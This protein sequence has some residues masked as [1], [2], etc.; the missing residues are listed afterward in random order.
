MA[1]FWHLDSWP[2]LVRE[3]LCHNTRFR[4]EKSLSVIL[5]HLH[6]CKP[7]QAKGQFTPQKAFPG[8]SLTPCQGFATCV[9][10]H[11]LNEL[12]EGDDDDESGLPLPDRA[13]RSL[14]LTP[15]SQV[16]NPQFMRKQTMHAPNYRAGPGSCR[17]T[18][19]NK[20]CKIGNGGGKSK[21]PLAA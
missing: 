6:Y 3:G 9:D 4:K 11:E 17:N 10:I 20:R 21:D 8:C 16:T 18:A 1:A 15:T 14:Q 7:V 13:Q 5:Y 19:V 12:I 2:K